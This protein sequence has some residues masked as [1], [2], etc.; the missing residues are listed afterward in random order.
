MQTGT[1][2]FFHVLLFACPECGSPVAC[3]CASTEQN[4]EVADAQ[5]FN[6]ICD[7][8]WTRPMIG[9]QAQKHWIEP[10]KIPVNVVSEDGD[11]SAWLRTNWLNYC[12]P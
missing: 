9:A 5:W 7:C 11:H 6:P 3:A 12:R 2:T 1:D 4:L 10:W 8:G